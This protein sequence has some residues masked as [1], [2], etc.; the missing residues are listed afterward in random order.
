MPKLYQHQLDETYYTRLYW[1]GVSAIV[2]RQIH[3]DGVRLLKREGVRLE[4]EIPL[5]LIDELKERN[6][7]ATKEEMPYW[8]IVDWAPKWHLIDAPKP[9]PFPKENPFVTK[10]REAA[11]AA[12]RAAEE[13]K[14]R[15]AEAE[16]RAAEEAE[17]QKL[18]AKRE[19]ERERQRQYRAR[20]K[21]EAEAARLEMEESR[22]E[23]ESELEAARELRSHW[24]QHK[25]E[26]IQAPLPLKI[27]SVEPYGS[28]DATMTPP[29]VPIESYPLLNAAPSTGTGEQPIPT[30]APHGSLT[31]LAPRAQ[32]V[33]MPRAA[34]TRPERGS[35]RSFALLV[36]AFIL[37]V[38]AIGQVL[39]VLP[40]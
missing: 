11:R 21:A 25:R 30:N 22:R 35:L 23:A 1:P 29:Q 8:G 10:K 16:R 18:E 4:G 14:R 24:T 12:R 19:A 39:D 32:Q 37:L 31:Q 2:T 7:L 20:K 5:W 33:E 13:E 40:L 34:E 3:P 9:K 15:A 38:M 27:S 6:W 17:R 36:I 26:I 28:I